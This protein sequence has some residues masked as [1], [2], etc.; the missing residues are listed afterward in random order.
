MSV[1]RLTQ[2]IKISLIRQLLNYLAI[3][4]RL[5]VSLNVKKNQLHWQSNK[6]VF[7]KPPDPNWIP[8][9]TTEKYN[10]EI[11]EGYYLITPEFQQILCV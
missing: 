4:A 2:K 3:K 1:N 10:A 7:S 11:S 8:V 6:E 5:S 9:L